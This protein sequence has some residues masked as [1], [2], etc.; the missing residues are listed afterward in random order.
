M[1]IQEVQQIPGRVKR[2]T[3]PDIPQWCCIIQDQRDKQEI[4]NSIKL[5]DWNNIFNMIKDNKC[6]IRNLFKWKYL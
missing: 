3:H 2:T 4:L 1:N 5:D 6:Q